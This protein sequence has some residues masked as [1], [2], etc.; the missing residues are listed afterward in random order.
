MERGKAGRILTRIQDS[1]GG[2]LRI[3]HRGVPHLVLGGIGG[4]SVAYFGKTRKVRVFT[5]YMQS[6]VP[7]EKFD[8]GQWPDAKAFIQERL[9]LLRAHL[10]PALS[11]T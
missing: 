4:L 8:F 7:Q 6:I 5:G 11:P 1:V 3:S 9:G 10:A 2:E